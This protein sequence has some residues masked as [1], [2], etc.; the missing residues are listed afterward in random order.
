[1]GYIMTKEEFLKSKEQGY[2]NKYIGELFGLTARQVSC[3]VK[4]WGLDYSNKKSVN[5]SFFSTNNKAAYYW[6]GFLAADGYIETDRSRVGL[7]LQISDIGHLEKFKSALASEHD[8][9]EFMKGSA[10]RIRL[11]SEQ[12]VS[13]LVNKFNITTRK[14][15]TYSMPYFEEDY[16]LLEFLR[17][18]IEGDGHLEKTSS[19]RVCVH[20]CSAN[21]LF[22]EEFK[23]IC[24]VLLDTYIKQQVNLNINKK[25]QVYT[26]RLNL[27]DSERL[28]VLL[29]KNSTEATRLDRKYV[30]AKLILDKG[31]VL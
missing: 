25:G 8:I 26:I 22:L 13:D 29:Y 5:H 7:G 9:C 31:I 11:N 20:L 10:A 16:L 12:I 14:T 6:A 17:G 21:K 4:N 24:E 23:S 19:G 30:V 18:Y 15:F 3:R 1:M 27:D 28:I 2:T